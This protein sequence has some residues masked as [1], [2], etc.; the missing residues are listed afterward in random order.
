MSDIEAKKMLKAYQCNDSDIY[1]AE[2]EE[3]AIEVYREYTGDDFAEGYPSELTAE[4]LDKEIPE[5]DEN[6]ARTGGITSI[7]KL[8]SE[9]GAEPS[10]LCTDIC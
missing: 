9:H 4:E 2:S 7:R 5:I 1:A 10:P 3:G 6:D 8:L